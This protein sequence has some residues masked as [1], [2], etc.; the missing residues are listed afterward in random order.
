MSQPPS[1][2]AQAGRQRLSETLVQA[3]ELGAWLDQI[4][5]DAKKTQDHLMSWRTGRDSRASLGPMAPF[6][7]LDSA[8]IVLSSTD[9]ADDLLDLWN[10]SF[11][12]AKMLA[13][14]WKPKLRYVAILWLISSWVI[15]S[16]FT[17]AV[18]ILRQMTN[19]VSGAAGQTPSH[20]SP[21]IT[22]GISLCL[23]V[24]GVVLLLATAFPVIELAFK[25]QFQ[26]GR[27]MRRRRMW[28]DTQ[29]ALVSQGW[30]YDDAIHHMAMVA[31]FKKRSGPPSP[32]ALADRLA[33]DESARFAST[34]VLI[35]LGGGSV[36][37]T[38]ISLFL[39]LAQAYERL[40][41]PV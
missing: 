38:L 9:K 21:A 12:Q 13:D 7:R 15:H 33:N 40:E 19:A 35:V 41:M 34:L 3:V 10:A 28:I 37:L 30:S 22:I 8:A 24:G 2:P 17:N 6:D 39:P 4:P 16:Q 27:A 36:L 1:V 14:I 20:E 5:G 23:F 26:V 29:S 25:R 31:G 18:P 11:V 32:L